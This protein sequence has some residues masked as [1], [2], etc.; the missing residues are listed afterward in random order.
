MTVKF[1][2]IFT[3]KKNSTLQP[4]GT[5]VDFN[6]VRLKENTSFLS[7]TLIMDGTAVST[8]TEAYFNGKYYFV[9]DVRSIPGGQWEVDLEMDVLATHKSSIG[10]YTGLI[11]RTADAAWFNPCIRDEL[12]PPTDELSFSYSSS[13][14]LLYLFSPQASQNVKTFYVLNVM[15]DASQTNVKNPNGLVRTYLLYPDEMTQLAINLNTSNIWTQIKNNIGNPMDSIVSCHLMTFEASA[16]VISGAVERIKLGGVDTGKDAKAIGNRYYKTSVYGISVPAAYFSPYDS[17]A[18]AAPYVTLTLYLPYVGI[19]PLDYSMIQ[20]SRTIYYQLIV[21][22]V[23]GDI[24]YVLMKTQ[25]G[26]IIATY[27]GNM[28][29]KCPVSSKS[30]NA[31]QRVGGAITAIGGLAVAAVTGGAA[32]AAGLGTAAAGAGQVINSLDV[33]TQINGNVSSNMGS[34]MS[35]GVRINAYVRKPAHGLTDEYATCGLPAMKVGKPSDHPGFCKFQ[36]ASV[37]IAD[38]DVVR[39][40]VND[41]LVSGF[42]YE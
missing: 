39:D 1:W 20:D 19:V 14:D 7:P 42:Y 32:A 22:F 4:T 27:E 16:S 9:K 33:H 15:G 21:D 35:L 26:G 13:S 6:N 2:Q 28:A 29:T 24:E 23:T 25:G 10:N 11:T 38:F 34:Q 5:S 31:L 40:R 12:N 8:A 17:Y 37:P 18:D 41:F 36:E 3:K 30:F